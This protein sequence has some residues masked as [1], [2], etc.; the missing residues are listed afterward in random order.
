MA[1][2]TDLLRVFLEEIGRSELIEAV[3]DDLNVMLELGVSRRTHIALM[4]LGLSRSS[5]VMRSEIITDDRMDEDSAL[6]WLMEGLWRQ[7]DLPQLV[8]AEIDRVIAVR[9]RAAS[10]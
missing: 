10:G 3:P 8:R 2:Y 9:G 4:G 6:A 7:L 1:C 5:A